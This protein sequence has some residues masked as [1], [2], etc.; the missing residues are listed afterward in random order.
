MQ[1]LYYK[2]IFYVY[3]FQ[4]LTFLVWKCLWTRFP[5]SDFWHASWLGWLL[6]RIRIGAIG[7]RFIIKEIFKEIQ[8]LY[9]IVLYLFYCIVFVKEPHINSSDNH[10]IFCSI[11]S[12]GWVYDLMYK[13]R[14]GW[15]LL[16]GVRQLTSIIA[17]GLYH[18]Y[19]LLIIDLALIL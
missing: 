4:A 17:F 13:I 7:S 9:Y 15:K 2:R 1:F 11:N 10:Q 18:L 12:W 6:Y 14:G 19:L 5:G 16:R 3:I 8:T